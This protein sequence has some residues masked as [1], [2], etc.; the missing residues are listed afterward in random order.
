MRAIANEP[1]EVTELL[2]NA[3]N[4]LSGIIRG[5]KEQKETVLLPRT[6]DLYAEDAR[7]KKLYY[8]QSGNAIWTQ[9]ERDLFVLEPGDM[10]GVPENFGLRIGRIRCDAPVTVLEYDAGEFLGKISMNRTF[11]RMWQEFL[12]SQY[13]AMTWLA[14]LIMEGANT[15]TPRVVSYSAG[16]KI[17]EQGTNTTD[18][19]TLLDGGC[20]NVLVDGVKVAEIGEN[21]LFGMFAALTDGVRTASVEA[22]CPSLGVVV[23][24]DDFVD[25]FKN[26]PELALKAMKDLVLHVSELNA[27]VVTLS[28]EKEK[29][30]ATRKLV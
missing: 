29:I 22:A 12:S 6:E 1:P 8:I 9:E 7:W 30:L 27:R 26:M 18:V 17:I 21:Q 19:Y 16:E 10:I 13:T 5:M 25:L 11:H 24:R 20:A 15:F 3:R 2:H 4:S 14:F 23:S 28:R